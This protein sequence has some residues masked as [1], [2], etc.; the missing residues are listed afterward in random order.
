MKKKNINNSAVWFRK[1]KNKLRHLVTHKKSAPVLLVV[2]F[3]I[4]QFCTTPSNWVGWEGVKWVRVTNFL[5]LTRVT[6]WLLLHTGFLSILVTYRWA[7]VTC[8]KSATDKQPLHIKCK[9]NV[10]NWGVYMPSFNK[11][12]LLIY[13]LSG[14]G[15]RISLKSYL[16]V[17]S[18]STQTAILQF[19]NIF[20]FSK[21]N[22]AS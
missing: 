4:L 7:T 20:Y 6:H 10:N 5:N 19:A 15:F 11:C 12:W 1:W 22:L 9:V 21:T 13:S 2:H 16:Q 14:H 8:V 17:A 3:Y 18:L